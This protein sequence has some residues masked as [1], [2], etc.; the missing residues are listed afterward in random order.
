MAAIDLKN[1]TIKIKDGA[2]HE[3]EVTIGEGNISYTEK[4]NIV[5]TKDRGA[6][7]E[8]R[9][10][11]EEPVEVSMDF[12]WEFLKAN[13]GDDP[14]IEDALKQRGEASGWTST[15]SDACRPY[16]VDIEILYTPPCG[17]IY[18]E[19]IVLNDFRYEQLQHDIKNAQVSCSGKC[20]ITEATVTREAP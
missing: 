20:N 2:S 1:A 9:E 12:V 15:D 7:D 3:L 16:A 13:T 5:Y 14:T 8:V 18:K 4:R 6:L 10:G 11:D 17:G 19:K